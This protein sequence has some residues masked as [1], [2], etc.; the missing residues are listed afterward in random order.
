MLLSYMVST[1][2][3]R[4]RAAVPYSADSDD[5]VRQL[6]R[7]LQDRFAKPYGLYVEEVQATSAGSPRTRITSADTRLADHPVLRN[8]GAR[9]ELDLRP[10]PPSIVVLAVVVGLIVFLGS[11]GLLAMLVLLVVRGLSGRRRATASA[12]A[13]FASR[14]KR[15]RSASRSKRSG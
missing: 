13:S 15:S 14:S 6:L 3:A 2:G 12:A 9:I 5:T 4:V 1:S 10:V 8:S 11:A 7:S